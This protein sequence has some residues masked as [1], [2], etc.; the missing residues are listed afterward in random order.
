MNRDN[1]NN[2]SHYTYHATGQILE[3]YNTNNQANVDFYSKAG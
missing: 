1:Y 2:G 3:E